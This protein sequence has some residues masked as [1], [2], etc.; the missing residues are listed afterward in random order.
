M[1]PLRDTRFGYHDAQHQRHTNR[2]TRPWH[3]YFPSLTGLSHLSLR[4]RRSPRRVRTALKT[5][6]APLDIVAQ[7]QGRLDDPA[8]VGCNETE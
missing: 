7:R 2:R 1:G 8:R 6:G 5:R 4:T 3:Y